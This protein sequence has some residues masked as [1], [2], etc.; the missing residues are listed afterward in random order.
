MGSS[1][2]TPAK[3]KE[4]LTLAACC[5][6]RPGA[7]RSLVGKSWRP[8]RP[9][10]L[11]GSVCKVPGTRSGRPLV[12]IYRQRATA[13]LF[14]CALTGAGRAP[15]EI[16]ASAIRF[17]E[18]SCTTCGNML[19]PVNPCLALNSRRV[20]TR[21]ASPNAATIVVRLRFRDGGRGHARPGH[22]GKAGR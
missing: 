1:P 16:I 8:S 18:F 6:S 20:E 12:S 22:R 5:N 19:R 15:T 3:W 14:L 11:L 17:G 10:V 2:G 7:S 21:R 9:S 4:R 13:E